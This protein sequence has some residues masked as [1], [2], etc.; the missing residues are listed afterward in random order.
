MLPQ[1][2]SNLLRLSNHVC[3]EFSSRARGE[4]TLKEATANQ[5][6]QVQE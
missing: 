3:T 4:V 2:V 6:T 5:A 1:D